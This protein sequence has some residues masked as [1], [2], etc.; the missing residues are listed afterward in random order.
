MACQNACLV[1]PDPP[2]GHEYRLG[3]GAPLSNPPLA[4]AMYRLIHSS[5]CS[6]SGT[7]TLLPALA[8]NTHDALVE[9]EVGEFQAD[10][11]TDPQTGG[12]HGFEHC[13]VTQAQG[14]FGIGRFQQGCNP[15]LRR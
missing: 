15:D 4:S 3:L 2:G 7:R 1:M 8:Q 5:A 9:V 13:P 14:R 10:Q 6:P 11:F 12:I